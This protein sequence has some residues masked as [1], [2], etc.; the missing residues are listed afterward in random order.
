MDRE[1]KAFLHGAAVGLA[2]GISVC[3]LTL[4]ILILQNI[5]TIHL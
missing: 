1:M 4:A 3:G 2:V 5:I